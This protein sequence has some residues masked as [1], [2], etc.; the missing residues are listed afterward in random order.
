M[1]SRHEKSIFF[2]EAE[3]LT[4]VDKSVNNYNEKE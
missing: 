3:L 1:K 2:E 4:D